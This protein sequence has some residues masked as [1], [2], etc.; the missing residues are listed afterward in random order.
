IVVNFG[1]HVSTRNGYLGA[2]AT[3]LRIG[4]K[5]F[6]YFPKNP[7]SLMT[8]DFNRRDA[9]ACA[10]YCKQH[11]LLSIGHS[12]YPTNLA[13]DPGE[14]RDMI[15]RSIMND[16]HIAEACASIGTVVH[17][18]KY[19]GTDPLQGYKNI[20]TLL[21]KVAAQWQGNALILVENQAGTGNK[22]GVTIE[23]MVQIRSLC[24]EPEKIGFCF[25]T[26]HAFAS[27]LWKG[28]NWPEIEAKGHALRF[29]DHV[30]AIHLNDSVYP[31][32]SFRDR[33]ANIGKGYIG[34]PHMKQFLQSP[35][36]KSLPIVLETPNLPKYSHQDEIAFLQQL[37]C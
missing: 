33:H 27:G 5:S 28:D 20:L 15:E 4:G 37:V 8:K 35:F 30:K 16:L 13:V 25:D 26:C 19:T 31:A 2:A 12:A 14:T 29:W 9:Q 17:F 18:G 1:S 7:R 21:N 23:E 22:M 10:E 24:T 36:L 11:G 6:Q 34:T 32:E 3:A